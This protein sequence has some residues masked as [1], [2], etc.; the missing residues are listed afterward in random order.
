MYARFLSIA[1]SLSRNWPLF[2]FV[3]IL[4]CSHSI[5]WLTV[6][7]HTAKWKKH[8]IRCDDGCTTESHSEKFD[9]FS[10]SSFVCMLR[11]M[12]MCVRFFYGSAWMLLWLF[13]NTEPTLSNVWSVYV[14]VCVCIHAIAAMTFTYF[15]SWNVTP[16]MASLY[17]F[18]LDKEHCLFLSFPPLLEHSISFEE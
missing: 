13:V 15:D 10:Q 16:R 17:L 18:R 4:F 3:Y 9:L 2:P 14:R 6:C 7:S 11:L 1:L 5:H 12:S 8:T